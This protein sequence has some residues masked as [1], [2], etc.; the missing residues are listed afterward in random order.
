MTASSL[1]ENT[2]VYKQYIRGHCKD[3]CLHTCCFRNSV[4]YSLKSTRNN[5]RKAWI[6]ARRLSST[7]K[8]SPEDSLNPLRPLCS[9]NNSPPQGHLGST[10]SWWT[11]QPNSPSSY[12][13]APWQPQPLN[14]LC[15]SSSQHHLAEPCQWRAGILKSGCCTL[16]ALGRIPL[17]PPP[18]ESADQVVQMWT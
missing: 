7:A 15:S 12:P 13:A 18:V 17:G 4:I 9:V 6:F 1:P 10:S 8:L 14:M 2:T 5:F 16:V 3:F 11:K